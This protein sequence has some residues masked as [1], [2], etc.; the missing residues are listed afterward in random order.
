MAVPLRP[1]P[2]P[3][4]S[5]LMAVKKNVA[6]CLNDYDTVRVELNPEPI[7]LPRANVQFPRVKVQFPRANVQFLELMSTF[8]D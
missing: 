8:L 3:I 5:S 4:P 2:L 7:I 6:S 1:Y